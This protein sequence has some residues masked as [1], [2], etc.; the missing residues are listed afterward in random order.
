MKTDREVALEEVLRGGIAAVES[1]VALS[2]GRITPDPTRRL[3][4]R[5][6]RS[7][8]IATGD[9]RIFLDRARALLAD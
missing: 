9:A 7:L 3:A 6:R 2:E 5:A 1:F 8:E 4:D